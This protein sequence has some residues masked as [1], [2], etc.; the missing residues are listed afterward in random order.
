MIRRR[1]LGLDRAAKPVRDLIQ[2]GDIGGVR[3]VA[4]R[5]RSNLGRIQQNDVVIR[6]NHDC[7]RTN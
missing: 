6:I 3:S 5:L 1:E 4:G 2:G 7:D